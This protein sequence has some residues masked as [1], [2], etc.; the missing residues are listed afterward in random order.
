M[1]LFKRANPVPTAFIPAAAKNL[2]VTQNFI[3]EGQFHM[4]IVTKKKKKKILKQ[5]FDP[6]SAVAQISVSL[7]FPVE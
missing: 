5:V 3:T 1:S 7:S 2:K 6:K 4:E